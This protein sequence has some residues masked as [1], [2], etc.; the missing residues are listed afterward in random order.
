M[1]LKDDFLAEIEQRMENEF[2]K[3]ICIKSF[4]EKFERLFGH[5][6]TERGLLLHLMKSAH[7][8]DRK[9]RYWTFFFAQVVRD[10]TNFAI[11][12]KV[13]I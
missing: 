13:K 10:I 11:K 8:I 2:G 6:K 1:T 7:N 4:S 5:H 3:H 9:D 12:N